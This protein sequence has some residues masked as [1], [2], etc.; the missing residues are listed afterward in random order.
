MQ[1]LVLVVKTAD[2][3]IAR[4]PSMSTLNVA[5]ITDGTDTVETGYVVNGSAKAYGKVNQTASGH[6]LYSQSLNISSTSDSGAGQTSL[7]FT[8][9]MSGTGYSA[10]GGTDFG[11]DTYSQ[12]QSRYLAAASFTVYSSPDQSQTLSDGAVSFAIHG[13]L[14]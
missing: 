4:R 11:V 5:N 7:S 1:G 12:F 14:A 8:S 13:D 3:L 10:S 9:S 6:P 2:P